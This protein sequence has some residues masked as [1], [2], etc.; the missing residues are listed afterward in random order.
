MD[1]TSGCHHLNTFLLQLHPHNQNQNKIDV[2]RLNFYVGLGKGW[3]FMAN[4][5]RGEEKCW[6]WWFCTKGCF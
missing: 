1:C 2:E 4:G 6:L 5:T 3:I